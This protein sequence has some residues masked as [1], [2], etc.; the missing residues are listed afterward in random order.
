M[1][2]I[3]FLSSKIEIVVSFCDNNGLYYFLLIVAIEKEARSTK[4]QVVE[5]V[6]LLKS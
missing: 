6:W 2:T 1:L 4:S 5:R 3:G